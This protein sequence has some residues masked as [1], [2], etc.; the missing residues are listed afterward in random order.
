MLDLSIE[1]LSKVLQQKHKVFHSAQSSMGLILTDNCPVGCKH[2]ISSN[3]VQKGNELD[4]SVLKKRVDKICELGLFEKIVITGG[5]PFY[6]FEKLVELIK[7][8]KTKKLKSSVVSGAYWAK[9]R[10]KTKA[11]IGRL[12][13]AGLNSIALSMDI[14]HQEKIP[15]GNLVHVIKTCQELSLLYTMVFTKSGNHDKDKKLLDKFQNAFKDNINNKLRITEGKMLNSGRALENNLVVSSKV[16][17]NVPSLTCQSMGKIIRSDGQV[18][19]CCGADLPKDSPLLVGNID[20]LDVPE[21]K[22]KMNN[23]HLIPFIEIYGLRFMIEI[24]KK[25]AYDLDIDLSEL[26]SDDRC[27]I[28]QKLL[29]NKQHNDFFKKKIMEPEIQ[30]DLRS[31]YLLLFGHSFI[32]QKNYKRG[33]N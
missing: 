18:A 22:H 27:T 5:E 9:S 14:Y 12:V 15:Y 26:K 31:K 11:V 10:N 32:H 19:L 21:L 28:C 4:L 6:E 30:K 29:A 17:N 8:I 1:E 25:E 7:Y 16:E 23:N 20:L 24:L 13:G 3:K 33:G 2:C